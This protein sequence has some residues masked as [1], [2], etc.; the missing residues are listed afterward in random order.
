MRACNWKGHRASRLAGQH[1]LGHVLRFHKLDRSDRELS[2]EL[3]HHACAKK[4]GSKTVTVLRDTYMRMVHACMCI[5]RGADRSM[6]TVYVAAPVIYGLFGLK[7]TYTYVGVR[8][9][10]CS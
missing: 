4:L 3:V 2:R 7:C 9:H 6:A 5:R 8:V 10:M 1:I